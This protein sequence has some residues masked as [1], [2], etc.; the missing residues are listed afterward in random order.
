MESRQK[1]TKKFWTKLFLAPILMFF[2]AYAMVP[3]YDVF[4]EITGF[5]GTTGRVDSE[6]AYVVDETRKI[7][8]SFF[9][10][11]M[12]GFPVQFGPKVSSMVV[13]PGKFYTTSYIAKNNTDEIVVGQ[14]VPS[15]APTDAAA[16]FKKLE[17]FCF[18]KQVFKP[19]EQ[20]EMT[21]RFVIEP[22][23][24]ERIKDV[25]LSYNFFKLKS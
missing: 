2:F 11:T 22:E 3:I 14:A 19:H 5:N 13:I 23:L 15:V 25:S 8:V 12:G 17:C 9:A 10:M 18:N 20:V 6:Q 7:E 4:C 21:L 16:Y 1:I 24:D